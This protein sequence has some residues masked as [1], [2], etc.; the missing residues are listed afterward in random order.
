[1]R[2][3]LDGNQRELTRWIEA[4]ETDPV[5]SASLT[6]DRAANQLWHDELLRLLFNWSSSANALVEH[7]RAVM[8]EFPSWQEPWDRKRREVVDV[9][10]ASFVSRLRAV[11]HHIDTVPVSLLR[12][13]DDAREVVTTEVVMER[14]L[15]ML[16]PE[17]WTR[18][19]RS[20]IECQEP[21]FSLGDVV[22]HYH[23][24][25]TSLYSWLDGYIKDRRVSREASATWPDSGMTASAMSSA[26]PAM[27]STLE[28]APRCSTRL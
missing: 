26:R 15:L 12:D 24:Q 4:L 6:E 21:V 11:L 8:A 28:C 22:R 19:S 20:F 5:M 3:V 1:M 2:L 16:T 25:V 27:N 13:F 10:L 7:T 17:D 14:G 9:G 18:T 23:D